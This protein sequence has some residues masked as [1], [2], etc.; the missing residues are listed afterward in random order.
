LQT[1]ISED[2]QSTHFSQAY[3]LQGLAQYRLGSY[4]A[5]ADSW[6]TYLTLRPGYL[7][8]YTQELRGDAL[9]EAGNYAEALPSYKAAIQAPHLG[10]AILDMK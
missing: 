2:P 9:V 1:L 5:A 10:D 8:S 4:A 6:Q 7:D 3:F